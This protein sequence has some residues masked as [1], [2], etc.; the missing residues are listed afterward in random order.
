VALILAEETRARSASIPNQVRWVCFECECCGKRVWRIKYEFVSRKHHY[1]SHACRHKTI[2]APIAQ[3]CCAVCG[4]TILRKAR[5]LRSK[6]SLYFC[7]KNCR[8]EA[9]RRGIVACGPARKTNSPLRQ[10]YD[11]CQRCGRPLVNKRSKFCSRTCSSHYRR[12]ES[13]RKWLLNPIEVTKTARTFLCQKAG[14]KC[15]KCGWSVTNP[16]TG[17]VPLEVHHKDGDYRNCGDENLE[18]LCPNCHSL[19]STFRGANAGKGRYYRMKKYHAG[20]AW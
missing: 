13:E 4:N 1:C 14:N 10:V 9:A 5:Q 18:V 11:K 3:V 15:S 20:K 12:E 17:K 6:S 8:Q 7:N 2:A 16:H 19:T